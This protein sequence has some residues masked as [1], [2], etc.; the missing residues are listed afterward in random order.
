MASC[1][2]F[3][4]KQ[5]FCIM[6][7]IML[8]WLHRAGT[9]VPRAKSIYKQLNWTILTDF[10]V[11]PHTICLLLLFVCKAHQRNKYTQQSFGQPTIIELNARWHDCPALWNFHKPGKKEDEETSNRP[12]KKHTYIFFVICHDLRWIGGKTHERTERKG[13]SRRGY[14]LVFS[15]IVKK[16]Y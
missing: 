11:T 14:S 5:S 1:L 13:F 10:H 8:S 2:N 9:K 7:C 16:W 12:N 6:R 3:P 4:S 15:Y